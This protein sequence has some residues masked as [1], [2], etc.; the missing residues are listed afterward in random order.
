MFRSNAAF[1]ILGLGALSFIHGHS[2]PHRRRLSPDTN[3]INALHEQMAEGIDHPRFTLTAE[4]ETQGGGLFTSSEPF[5]IDVVLTNPSVAE[6]TSFSVDG[7]PR[8]SVQSTSKFFIADDISDLDLSKQFAILTVD[9][10][11][12]LVSGLVQKDGKLL[13]LEQRLGGPTFVTEASAFD[14]P[15]D[16]KCTVAHDTHT[17]VAKENPPGSDGGGRRVEQSHEHH[18]H[19]THHSHE[20]GHSHHVHTLN[21]NEADSIFSQV[22]NIDP[23]MLHGRRR[24]Y[25]TDDFPLKWSYQ[26]KRVKSYKQQL[27]DIHTVLTTRLFF[28]LIFTLKLTKHW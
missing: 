1:L 27:I 15:K 2:S 11:Q 23:N 3:I 19:H 10:E 21:L 17:P 20:D 14:P 9:E 6:T 24:L 28:Q 26:G 7:G 25:Q 12:G 5:D 18:E 8:T 4:Y 13:R 22:A 16:W